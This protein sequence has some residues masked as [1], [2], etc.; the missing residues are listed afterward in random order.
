MITTYVALLSVV[1]TVYT[2]QSEL[3]RLS[4][5]FGNPRSVESSELIAEE[6]A[7]RC[8]FMNDYSWDDDR[9]AAIKETS[10]GIRAEIQGDESNGFI[11]IMLAWG[12]PGVRGRESL[13]KFIVPAMKATEITLKSKS[14]VI[15]LSENRYASITIRA[16]LTSKR[17]L[18]N[19]PTICDTIE[20]ALSHLRFD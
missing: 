14:C 1:I 9:L 4:H 2:T 18:A 12:I 11:R 8:P 16:H 3:D 19:L 6:I 7:V 10:S 15:D 13:A 20:K 17:A 5:A